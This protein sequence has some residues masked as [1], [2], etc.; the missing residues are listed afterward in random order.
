MR[1]SRSDQRHSTYVI[2]FPFQ[3]E[4]IYALRSGFRARS[5]EGDDDF[6][7]PTPQSPPVGRGRSVGGPMSYSPSQREGARGWD[8]GAGSL[9]F[10]N[11]RAFI[12]AV[13]SNTADA[14]IQ[15]ARRG[16]APNEVQRPARS[17]FRMARVR[18]ATPARSVRPVPRKRESGCC[19]LDLAYPA[20]VHT[21]LGM[22]Q[23]I[24]VLHCQPAF[25]RTPERFG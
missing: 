6:R 19:K 12:R 22:P 17:T 21:L 8:S 3:E 20:Q 9:A 14:S 13:L 23:I 7:S 5:V 4:G 18:R 11:S 16:K 1:A 15:G 10:A 25:R 2:R 24:V